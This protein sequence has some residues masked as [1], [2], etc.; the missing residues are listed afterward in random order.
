[1]SL[2]RQLHRMI[3][4]NDYEGLETF[5]DEHFSMID[6]DDI[7]EATQ[8]ASGKR[9]TSSQDMVNL[10]D[11]FANLCCRG[12]TNNGKRCKYA[13]K[14]GHYCGLHKKRNT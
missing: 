9:S 10:L 1:M 5:L 11:D 13:A 8:Y 12:F 6:Y 14:I 7:S 2:T 4:K 3:D